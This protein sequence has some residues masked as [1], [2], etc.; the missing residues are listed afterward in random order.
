VGR[1]PKPLDASASALAG[2]GAELRK[3]RLEQG[4]TLIRLGELTGYSRQHLGAVER[5][6]VAPSE[7]VVTACE[8]AL[9]AGGQLIALFPAVV[10]EQAAFRH[11]RETTRHAH[12]HVPDQ[13]IDWSHLATAATR[14]SVSPGMVEQLELI[15]DRQ[16]ALYHELTSAEML[17]PVQAHLGLLLSL[18]EATHSE[19]LRHRI[20]SAASEAAGFAAWIWHDL[21]DPYN[22]SRHYTTAERLR[23][24]AA[25]PALHSYVT[26]YHA[27]ACG[28]APGAIDYAR[29]ALDTAPKATT[30]L[31]RSWLCAVAA[32]VVARVDPAEAVR[33]L[34]QARD[35][36]DAVEGREEW[37]YEFDRTALAGYRG[38]CHLQLG[39]PTDAIGA[40]AEAIASVPASCVRRKAQFT[41]G[42]A[43]AYLASGDVDEALTLASDSVR[44]F[45]SRG[46]VSGIS[47]VQRLR[48]L[49][50]NDGHVRHAAQLNEHARAAAGAKQ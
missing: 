28:H 14:S 39:Q 41:L 10:R 30:H 24:E 38:Q 31:T 12:T 44:V 27:L 18:L 33:L 1:P 8:R 45:A 42:L 37:M 32:N 3:L 34:G 35:H 15:T 11:A 47:G 49:L 6:E 4:L 9:S 22:S 50:R 23:P 48:D 5:A 25:N 19:P 36:F 21:G 43:E 2:L 26:A 29:Q 46:S 17:V 20:A 16:R 13:D 7:D 40:F